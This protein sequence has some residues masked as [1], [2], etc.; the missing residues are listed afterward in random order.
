TSLIKRMKLFWKDLLS[1]LAV[2]FVWLYGAIEVPRLVLLPRLSDLSALALIWYIFVLVTTLACFLMAGQSNPGYVTSDEDVKQYVGRFLIK[3]RPGMEFCPKC[4]RERPVRSHHCSRCNCCVLEMD[5]HCPFVLN[6]IGEHNRWRFILLLFYGILLCASAQY[7]LWRDLLG[8]YAPTCG[9]SHAKAAPHT[10]SGGR[11]EPAIDS[12]SS[13]CPDYRLA[14]LISAIIISLIT[15]VAMGMLFTV[16]SIGI[17]ESRTTLELLEIVRQK[18]LP[19]AAD[20][21]GRRLTLF[22]S[23]SRVFGYDSPWVWPVP[24]RRRKDRLI[25]EEVVKLS[26]INV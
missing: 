26:S 19:S 23:M 20:S 10:L 14:R 13:P 21:R 17:R 16:Q 18:Q 11:I 12:S 1:Y 15:M 7:H 9:I 8:Y 22:E 5:H 4:N 2:W 3:D 6:C 25:D 24:C